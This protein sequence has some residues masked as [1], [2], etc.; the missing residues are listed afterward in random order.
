MNRMAIA[1]ATISA[2][3]FAC[4]LCSFDLCLRWLGLMIIWLLCLA[5]LELSPLVRESLCDHREGS[6]RRSLRDC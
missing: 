6:R 2:R 4:S 5:M 1:P 3:C